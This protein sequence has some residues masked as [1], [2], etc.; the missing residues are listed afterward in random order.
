[1]FERRRKNDGTTASIA[2][3]VAA[4]LLA[5]LLVPKLRKSLIKGGRNAYSEATASVSALG[6]LLSD[7]TPFRK[8]PRILRL[9]AFVPHRKRANKRRRG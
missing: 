5:P 6:E 8:R 7:A 9:G 4:V 3:G 2:V 1:M